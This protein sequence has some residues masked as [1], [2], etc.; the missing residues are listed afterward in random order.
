MS[1]GN[2]DQRVSVARPSRSIQYV[3]PVLLRTYNMLQYVRI[4]H[5]TTP[6]SPLILSCLAAPGPPSLFSN[7]VWKQRDCRDSAQS[8]ASLPLSLF[9]PLNY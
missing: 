3:V 1:P 6:P 9:L 8:Y 7:Q 2:V 5:P 4:V